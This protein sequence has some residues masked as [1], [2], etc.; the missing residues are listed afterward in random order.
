MG[1]LIAHDAARA[2]SN[3]ER[4]LQDGKPSLAT[5]DP[6]MGAHWAI[7]GNAL[8]LIGSALG[9]ATVAYLMQ[10]DDQ[11]ED[12]V[13]PERYADAGGRTWPRCP[14]CYVG[15]AHEL[16]CTDDGCT[17]PKVDGYA[18]MI[19]RAA[20]EQAERWQQLIAAEVAP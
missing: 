2:G 18:W 5:F 20:D 3:V 8:Q 17:L 9:S 16:T 19:D 15:L 4:E 1:H 11:P 10:P 14:L 6:L 13:D 12:P 7:N